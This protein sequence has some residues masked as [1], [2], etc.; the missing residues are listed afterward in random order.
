MPS[1]DP[2]FQSPTLRNSYLVPITTNSL[3]PQ[4]N[5]DSH[6][7]IDRQVNTNGQNH[8]LWRLSWSRVYVQLETKSGTGWHGSE[9]NPLK[10]WRKPH[11]P[12]E[13]DLPRLL[14][15]NRIWGTSGEKKKEYCMTRVVENVLGWA[16]AC[17]VP[18][19]QGTKVP[20]SIPSPSTPREVK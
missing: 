3:A 2:E 12:T 20:L 13:F 11:K 14:W 17:D 1:Q 4:A 6:R 8:R 16:M 5:E 18:Q 10:I 9:L 19:V 7:L 15:H